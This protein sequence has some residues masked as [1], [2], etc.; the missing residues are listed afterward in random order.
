MDNNGG[1]AKLWDAE[2]GQ[3]LLEFGGHTD[4]V[5]SVAFSPDGR[6]V[7]TG[8][9]DNT[10]KLW[11]AET[12]QEL[13]AF[14]GHSGFV[15]SLAFSPD[16]RRVLTGSRDGS[17]KLW[18]T[19]TG[20][21]LCSLISFTD[22][23][24]AVVDPEGRY[25]ASNGGD[26][27]GLHWVIGYASIALS[28]LKQRYYDPGLLAKY[29]GLN[30]E[31]L[32]DVAKLETPRLFPAVTLDAPSPGSTNLR[33]HLSNDGGGIG[34]VRVLVNG[35]EIAAD[36][37]GAKPNPGAAEADLTVDLAGAAIAPGQVNMIEV[38]AWNA[39]GYLSSRG[40]TAEW[41]APGA[42][43]STSPE[44]YAIVSGVSAYADPALRLNFSSQDAESFAHALELGGDR[45]FGAEHVHVT[46]LSS[47]GKPGEL[48]PTKENLRNAFVAAQKAKPADVFVVYFAGHGVALS[49]LYAYP[50]A[51][52]RTLDLSDP[53][54]RSQAAVTSDELVDW[55]KKIPARHQVMILDTCAAGAAAVKL[56]EKRDVP[57]DQ[58]RAIDQLKDRTGFYVLMGSAA[59]AVSYE[60]SRYGQGLLTYAL[61]TG[62][63][64]AA[65]KNDV[66]VD[67]SKLFQFAVD[68]VPGLARGIGG[69]QR[70]QI[71][72]PTGGASFDVG[73]LQRD[74]QK[75]I[76]LAAEKPIFLRPQLVNAEGPDDL[77]LAAAVRR[78]LR[79]ETYVGA[80]SG[81]PVPDAIF[82]DA[83]EMPGAIRVSGTYV[84]EEKKITVQL[85]LAREKQKTHV[86]VEGSA[87]E[88]SALATK[89]TAAVL[90][91]GKGL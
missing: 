78:E 46:V 4:G 9:W 40:V 12:G 65:L 87:E 18:D 8:S 85:W 90:D 55:I 23:T 22:G 37:R 60:A 82:V 49:D 26:V 86:V 80:R 64:G 72:A 79:N 16:G 35:K 42:A 30:G 20:S 17:A 5:A 27:S 14:Q 39:E 10:A 34:K 81:Q 63:K 76:H 70:P 61:L 62:M 84:V 91:A 67:V 44:L 45:L 59:D 38:V 13:R 7:L 54:V 33:I 29:M 66:D 51:N 57:G 73:E 56:V 89:I 52:A 19:E 36:A 6:R 28:Q 15:V 3:E 24:W 31:A 88:I 50:T 75:Q 74:D 11:D 69:V 21:E 2:T 71:I 1:T 77:E 32:L 58:V 41:T 53:A 48:A 47:S 68:D 43:D 83:D 25:D